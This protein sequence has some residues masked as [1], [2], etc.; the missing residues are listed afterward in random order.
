M[1]LAGGTA[2]GQYALCLVR[3]LATIPLGDSADLKLGQQVVADNRGG[4]GGNIGTD[5]VAKARAAI[6]P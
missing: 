5:I 2:T 4:A 1:T 3:P 6:E